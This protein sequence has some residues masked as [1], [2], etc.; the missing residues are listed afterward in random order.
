ME[1]IVNGI[2]LLMLLAV[3]IFLLRMKIEDGSPGASEGVTGSLRCL[4]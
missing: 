4:G 3:E 1:T 2:V